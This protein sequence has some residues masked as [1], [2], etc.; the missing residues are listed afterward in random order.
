MEWELGI[1]SVWREFTARLDDHEGK[2]GRIEELDVKT[3][4]LEGLEMFADGLVLSL[5]GC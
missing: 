3:L 4:G 2:V 5:D 1:V